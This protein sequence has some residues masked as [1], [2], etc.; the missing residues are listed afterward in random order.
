MTA[1]GRLKDK[2]KAQAAADRQQGEPLIRCSQPFC[3]RSTLTSAGTGFSRELCELHCERAQRHGDPTI[4]SIPGPILWPYTETALSFIKATGDA[5]VVVS[6]IGIEG[7]LSSAG[8]ALS[9]NELVG[10]PSATRA[11]AMFARMR[12]S[13]VP[14]SRI[15]ATVLGLYALLQDDHWQP[16]SEDFKL[17]QIGKALFRKMRWPKLEYDIALPVPIAA[18]RPG[19]DAPIVHKIIHKRPRPQGT[20]LRI[21]GKQLDDACG[22]LAESMAPLIIAQK[23]ARFGRHPCHTVPG[24]EPE[25]RKQDRA[26]HEAALRAREQAQAEAQRQENVR[27]L[28]SDVGPALSWQHR[29]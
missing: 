16:R 1:V 11:D 12:E 2:L 9:A 20:V 25:W 24:Y 4:P 19:E 21:I 5:R 28:L 29:R 17:T 6:L 8:P 14:P 22:S 18:L 15:M 23:D 13:K 26:K 27:Q 3:N 7:L 10:R